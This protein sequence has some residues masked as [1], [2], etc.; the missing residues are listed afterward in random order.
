MLRGVP[1]YMPDSPMAMLCMNNIRPSAY[2][3]ACCVAIDI[4]VR[5]GRRLR[6]LRA[7]RG[8]SQAYL[9]EISGIG[10]SHVSELENGRR[11]AGVARAGNAGTEFRLDHFRAIEDRVTVYVWITAALQRGWFTT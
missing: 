10:R 11:E 3:H 8:W 6:K 4:C 1:R 9:A 2:L 7:D 5:F